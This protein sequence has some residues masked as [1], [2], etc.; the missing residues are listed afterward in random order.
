MNAS[1]STDIIIIGAGMAGLS[2]ASALQTAG[3]SVRLFDKGRGPGGRMAT[4]RADLPEGQLHFDHGAQYFTARDPAFRE[5]V[6]IWAEAGAAAR[7]LVA[8]DDAWVG[9]PGMNGPIKHM[10]EQLD[11]IWGARVEAAEYNGEGW[12][13]S[14]A[15]EQYNCAKLL[16]AIPPEQVAELLKDAAPQLAAQARATRSLPCWAV[17]AHFDKPLNSLPDTIRSEDGPISWAARNGAKPSRKGGESWVI[18]ASPEKSQELLELEKEDA[19][20]ILLAGFFNQTGAAS[21]KPDYLTA[22]RWRYAMP[23]VENS[24]GAIWDDSQSIGLAGDWLHSPRVEGAWL[25]GAALA[26]AVLGAK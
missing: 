5:A 20:D 12:R 26:N 19:A 7:W 25:S 22:H 1:N 6:A 14:V 9:T 23:V 11:V 18:H 8:G 4:R 21:Q 2:C 16:V 13:V 10:A 15:G 17:L 24:Q 3:L